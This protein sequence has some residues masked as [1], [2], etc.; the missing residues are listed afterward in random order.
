MYDY[1]TARDVTCRAPAIYWAPGIDNT[2]PQENGAWEI[3]CYGPLERH[4]AGNTIGSAKK[5]DARHVV[6]LCAY[7]HANWAPTHSRL[8]LNYLN[9]IEDARGA[10]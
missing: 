3:E 10:T 7:H 6:L 8:I 9:R 2:N 4:H 5:T 1:V